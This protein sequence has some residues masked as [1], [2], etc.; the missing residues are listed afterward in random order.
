[1]V[2]AMTTPNGAAMAFQ[3]ANQRSDREEEV[4]GDFGDLTM[5]EIDQCIEAGGWPWSDADSLHDAM[6]E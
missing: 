3:A 4:R 6:P 2:P 1:M 5:A